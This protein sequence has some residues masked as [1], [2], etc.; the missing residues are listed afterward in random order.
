MKKILLTTLVASCLAG[1][2]FAQ[3]FITFSGGGSAATRVSTNSVVGGAATGTTVN[4]ANQYYF[5][6]FASTALTASAGSGLSASYVFGNLT[7]SAGSLGTAWELVGIGGNIASAGRYSPISQGNASGNQSALNSDNSLTVQGIGGGANA[8]LVAVGWSANIGSTLASVI[9]WYNNG[10]PAIP[11]WIGQSASSTQTL[12][13]GNLVLTPSNW[14]TAPTFLL[15]LVPTPE[16]GTMV[17][18]GLGGLSLLA[19]RRKK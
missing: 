1:S 4:V 13:D 8:N 12:G 2:A 6:L 16:P 17:L 3:G 7:T 10:S 11:G 9:A 15:V 14:N 19:L 5:A 18:A